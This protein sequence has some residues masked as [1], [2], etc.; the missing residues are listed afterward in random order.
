MKNWT[1]EKSTEGYTIKYKT[2]QKGISSLKIEGDMLV[3]LENLLSLIYEVEL[4]DQ[5][6][7]FVR[8]TT[9]VTYA[10]ILN[11]NHII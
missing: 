3:P 8:Q 1:T 4:F 6:V 2:N 11:T 10:N 9:L 5:W 7:P